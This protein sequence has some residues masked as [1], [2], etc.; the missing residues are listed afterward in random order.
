[1]QVWPWFTVYNVKSMI[2]KKEGVPP[3]KQFFGFQ[4]KR[5]QDTR[6]LLGDYNIQRAST[7]SL[8]LKTRP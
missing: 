3:E 6:T 8:D 5:L 1:M 2:S 4:G 7:L